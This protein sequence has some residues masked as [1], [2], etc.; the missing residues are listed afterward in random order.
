M[1]MKWLLAYK[2]RQEL[3]LLLGLMGLAAGLRLVA[4]GRDSLWFDEAVSY[5]AAS[6]PVSRILDNTVQSSHPPLYYL[7]LHFWLALGPDTDGF[8]RLLGV[9]WNVLLVPAVYLL[10][11][12]LF[13]QRRP[14][15]WAAGLVAVSYFHVLFSHELRMY[16]QL[17]FLVTVGVWAYLR[18]VR[19]G[20]WAWWLLF[21]VSFATAVYTHLF[22]WLALAAVG[23]YALIHHRQRPALERT[24]AAGFVLVIL[25]IPWVLVLVGE[26]QK[27]LGSMRPLAQ[28][29]AG[30]PIKPLIS[31]AF[32]TFGMSSRPWLSALVLFLTLSIVVVTLLEARKARREEQASE[33]LLPAFVVTTVVGLPTLVYLVRPFFLPDRTMAA[34]SPFLM[35]LLAWGTTRRGTPL[36]YLV[37]GAAVV[38]LIATGLYLVGGLQKPPYRTVVEFVAAQRQPGDAVLHTSD[39]S[40]LPALRYLDLHDHAVL[41]GD[42]DPRKPV[43]VYEALGGEVWSREAAGRS[44]QRL[45]LIVALEHSNEWQ[46]E[47]AGEFDRRYSR[48]AEYSFESG[49]G[50]IFVFLYDLAVLVEN[51]P[52]VGDS[53]GRLGD[54]RLNLWEVQ[55]PT[56]SGELWTSWK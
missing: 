51:L 52:E 54:H 53:A 26:S 9:L 18:A 55:Q 10:A 34:A 31:L 38:M 8:A 39:G 15:W 20:R 43:A 1:A 2:R 24:V 48:L 4:I 19:T 33:L 50:E 30:N 49:E 42:P 41:A 21:V 40:Y 37:Y 47:Q 7:L 3:F 6:L 23:L 25:F 16:T 5:L 46:E 14:A 11:L 12:E 27:E 22:A 56:L 32:L 17:M 29:T 36:P 35:L 45:W 44:G 13:D 28:A